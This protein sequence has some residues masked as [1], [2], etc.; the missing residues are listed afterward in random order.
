MLTVDLL[1][2]GHGE[3]IES[4]EST[5]A[6]HT[7]FEIPVIDDLLD[8]PIDTLFQYCFTDS[9]VFR[10]FLDARKTFGKLNYHY[11]AEEVSLYGSGTSASGYIHTI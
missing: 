6:G 3:R 10:R 2:L 11:A 7:H 1:M 8:I 5:C 4:G 9:P